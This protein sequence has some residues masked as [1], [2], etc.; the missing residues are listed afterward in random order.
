[1]LGTVL[2]Q[3]GAIDEAVVEFT[4][5]VRQMPQSIEAHRSL[6]TP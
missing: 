2:K 4:R 5:A 6:G 3:Q 1:M